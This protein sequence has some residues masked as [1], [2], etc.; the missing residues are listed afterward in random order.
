MNLFGLESRGFIISLGIT[1]LL[2]GLIMYYC[3]QRINS[4]EQSLVKQGE[5]IQT[6][7][8]KLNNKFFLIY[9]LYLQF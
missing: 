1:L 2:S 3:V 9:T 4:L 6:C 7:I 5:I 8:Y